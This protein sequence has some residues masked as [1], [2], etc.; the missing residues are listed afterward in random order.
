MDTEIL[1]KLLSRKI[2][3]DRKNEKATE[4]ENIT[5][6][7]K[8]DKLYTVNETAQ[9][10]RVQPNTIYKWKYNKKLPCVKSGSKLLF[11]G[12]AIKEYLGL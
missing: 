11:Q 4:K 9:I 8:P 6:T 1:Y 3:Y 7:I 10:L 2:E 5:Y 12:S